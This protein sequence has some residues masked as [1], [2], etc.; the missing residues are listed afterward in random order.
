[1]TKTF[2]RNC[3]EILDIGISNLFDACPPRRYISARQAGL[4]FGILI[5]ITLRF[6]FY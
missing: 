4:V 6:N 2:L 3:L 5:G 1:M